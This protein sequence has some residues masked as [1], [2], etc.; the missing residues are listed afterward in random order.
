MARASDGQR[1]TPVGAGAK[2]LAILGNETEL[3]FLH[4]LWEERQPGRS[5]YE[6]ALCFSG[7]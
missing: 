3:E 2:W 1:D 4:A 6:V 5:T 7:L